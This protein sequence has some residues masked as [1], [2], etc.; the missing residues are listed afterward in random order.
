MAHRIKAIR[1]SL[2]KTFQTLGP[3]GLFSIII[4]LILVSIQFFI[5]GDYLTGFLA[6]LMGAAITI[7]LIFIWSLF[8]ILE[9]YGKLI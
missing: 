5:T 6:I 2:K 3:S 7:I 8:N 9:W 1:I 4:A